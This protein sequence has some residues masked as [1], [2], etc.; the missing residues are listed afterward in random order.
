MFFGTKVSVLE[1]FCENKYILNGFLHMC[2]DVA[3]AC[4][5]EL[6]GLICC[7]INQTET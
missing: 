3:D 7:G 2:Y 4:V 1:L 6:V 5:V